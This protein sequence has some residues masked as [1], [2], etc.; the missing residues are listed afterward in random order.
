M[1]AERQDLALRI[2][3]CDQPRRLVPGDLGGRNCGCTSRTLLFLKNSSFLNSVDDPVSGTASFEYSSKV[4]PM[5]L[6][7]FGNLL[8]RCGRYLSV[9]FEVGAAYSGQAAIDVKL[10]GT[11]CTAQG[12]SM[13]DGS[14]DSLRQELIDLDSELK[15][16]PFYPIISLGLAYWS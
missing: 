13:R 16:F 15:P 4:A 5:L 9:P 8:P 2:K 7:G 11:A 12:C 1:G 10:A 6:I 14:A 3:L